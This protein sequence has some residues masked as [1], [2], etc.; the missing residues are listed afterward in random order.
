L[1][2]STAYSESIFAMLTFSGYL[3]AEWNNNTFAFICWIAASYTRSNGTMIILWMALRTIARIYKPHR[4]GDE[5]FAEIMSLIFDS[6]I[7]LFPV[8]YH[9]YNGYYIHCIQAHKAIRPPWCQDAVPIFGIYPYF[10]LLDVW[11]MKWFKTFPLYRHVQSKYWNVGFL[12]YY[13]WK[14]VPNFLLAFPV[15]FLGTCA[16]LTWI[17]QSWGFFT[18]EKKR[19][20]TTEANTW[21]QKLFWPVQWVTFAFRSFDTSPELTIKDIE[22]REQP[23]VMLVGPTYLAYY[24][25]LGAACIVGATIA[26]VQISTRF[27]FASCPAIYW[28]MAYICVSEDKRN[29]KSLFG[30][31]LL[32]RSAMI[33]YCV[34]F[35]IAGIV[36]HVNWLPWT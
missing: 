22:E 17:R 4:T 1:F 28:Y 10:A 21:R 34:G 12:R 6:L 20:S 2:F 7:I 32:S 25:V 26:H 3:F 19:D 31:L 13:E 35:N 23:V 15:L 11:D 29:Q 24:G 30:R 33:C 16:V 27:I 8:L 18:R 14:Q 5:R 36:M 9:D